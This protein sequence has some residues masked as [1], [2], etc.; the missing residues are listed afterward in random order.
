M[1]GEDAEDRI[2]PL[3]R[4]GLA[5]V[6]HD[7]AFFAGRIPCFVKGHTKKVRWLRGGREGW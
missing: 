6:S 3:E 1:R 5:C 4:G 2:G 7:G